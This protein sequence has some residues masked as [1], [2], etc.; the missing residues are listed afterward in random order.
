MPSCEDKGVYTFPKDI[1]PKVNVITSLE[2]ELAN[3]DFAVKY[4]NHYARG[5]HQ[6]GI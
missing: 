4:F 2:F 6:E 1:S 3:Y 5:T